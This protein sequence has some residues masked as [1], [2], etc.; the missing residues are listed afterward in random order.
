MC[1]GAFLAGYASE[2]ST[3][4]PAVTSN[5]FARRA[6]PTRRPAQRSMPQRTTVDRWALSIWLRTCGSIADACKTRRGHHRCRGQPAYF[7]Q[8]QELHSRARVIPERAQHRAGNRKRI[9]LLHPAHRHAEMRPFAHDRH[10]EWID[11]L[12]DRFGDLIGHPFLD[13]KPPRKHI[14]QARNLAETDDA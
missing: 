6:A 10:A 1:A 12:A 13:L 14:D 2:A 9:L 4:R 11:L 7:H 3:S 8:L 5:R